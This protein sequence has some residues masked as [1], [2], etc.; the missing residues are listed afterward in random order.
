MNHFSQSSFLFLP[1]WFLNDSVAGSG[2]LLSLG[3]IRV[4]VITEVA[5][6]A[7]YTLLRFQP[8]H[9][10][11]FA[12]TSSSFLRQLPLPPPPPPPHLSMT[13]RH[14]FL[15]VNLLP[16]RRRKPPGAEPNVGGAWCQSIMSSRASGAARMARVAP[17]VAN[18]RRR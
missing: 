14:S 4:L 3:L 16:R 17:E 18:T 10:N 6:C 15:Q 13:A 1:T 11:F 12:V 9:T 7:H 5:V 8:I 2:D